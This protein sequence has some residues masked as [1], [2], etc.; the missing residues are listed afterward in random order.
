MNCLNL[1]ESSIYNLGG[2]EILS[3]EE[4]INLIGSVLNIKPKNKIYER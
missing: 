1:E 4:I 3:L 2:P